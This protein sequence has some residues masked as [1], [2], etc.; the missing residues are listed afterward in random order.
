MIPGAGCRHH[1]MTETTDRIDAMTTP[2]VHKDPDALTLTLSTDLDVP[3][4]RAW[5]LWADPR[6]LEGWWGPPTY[7]A[8]VV[9]HDLTP[10]GRVS[11]FMTGPEGDEHHGWWQVLE[12]DAPNRLE[13][14][15]GFADQDGS[16]DE[17]LPTT[18]MTVTLTELDGGRSRMS[19]TSRFGTLEAMQELESMGVVEGMLGAMSQIDGVL[20]R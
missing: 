4:E 2:D 18:S 1:P 9:D 10:G 6:Q 13:V 12:V 7:P 17:D 11:Y 19:L 15:D 14:Q 3:V 16:P 20:A 5:Q 8:T